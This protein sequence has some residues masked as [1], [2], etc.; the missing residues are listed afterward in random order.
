MESPLPDLDRQATWAE[1]VVTGWGAAPRTHGPAP[2][3]VLC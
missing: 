3:P 2:T 1:T